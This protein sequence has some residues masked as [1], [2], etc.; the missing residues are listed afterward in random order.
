MAHKTLINGAYYEI[1]G[2]KA[3][4]NGTVY[5]IDHG[6]ANVGGTAYEVGF[7]KMAKVKIVASPYSSSYPIKA[8]VQVDGVV[9][10]L[11]VRVS[12]AA[13]SGIVWEGELPVGAEVILT[14]KATRQVFIYTTHSDGSTTEEYMGLASYTYTVIGNA[15]IE[16]K[17]IYTSTGP[18]SYAYDIPEFYITEIPEGPITF[19]I[20]EYSSG[21]KTYQAE[22]GMTWGEWV[23][24]EY[25]PYKDYT[26]TTKR[27][28][29][30]FDGLIVNSEHSLSVYY[31]MATSGYERFPD[32]TDFIVA[33]AY[34]E[35]AKD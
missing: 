15:N 24:S 10:D 5:E 9:Y 4:V 31:P 17:G 19:T 12:N 21:E 23:D 32:S 20:K 1:D 3:M 35:L 25:N 22:G 28:R 34:Y 6:V 11:S 33:N 18:G 13:I 8:S 29:V 26:H 16:V 27:Y 14:N 30:G 2:G 7:A